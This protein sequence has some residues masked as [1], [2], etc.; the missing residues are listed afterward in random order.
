MR[1]TFEV[2]RQHT[3][4]LPPRRILCATTD[5]NEV[6][7][8]MFDGIT[9][10]EITDHHPSSAGEPFR[11]NTADEFN[12]WLEAR[13]RYM[14]WRDRPR[15]KID[16]TDDAQGD[17]DNLFH[18]KE[19][20]KQHPTHPFLSE[21]NASEIKKHVDPKHYKNWIFDL[22]W[23]EAQQHLPRFR[24]NPDAFKGAVEILARKY[25]DRLGGKDDEV[26]E[27]LK[28]IWYYR[29]LAAYMANNCKPIRVAD[30]DKILDKV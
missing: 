9:F 6:K 17:A 16:L 14:Q 22:Q 21:D 19:E 8:E 29:F 27:V 23:I 15:K 13:A 30:I 25:F 24:D 20:K 18:L 2:Y 28:G 5:P 10:V 26:Q 4:E 3:E 7:D 1:F 11:F 12:E